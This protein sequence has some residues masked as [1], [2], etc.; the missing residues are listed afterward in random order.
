M[1]TVQ[2]VIALGDFV[3]GPVL[4]A[5]ADAYGRKGFMLIAPAIQV[6]LSNDGVF[7]TLSTPHRLYDATKDIFKTHLRALIEMIRAGDPGRL[8][9]RD[10][11]PAVRAR[12]GWCCHPARKFAATSIGIP[13][14][15]RGVVG[16]K[17]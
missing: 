14:V 7:S 6:S 4:G 3:I 12:R 15:R 16:W 11:A 9:C 13:F 1:S 5:A 2:I 8:P 10:R 17:Q